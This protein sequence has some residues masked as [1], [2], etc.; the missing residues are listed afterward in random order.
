MKTAKETLPQRTPRP[1]ET[2]GK[3]LRKAPPPT[4]EAAEGPV[5]ASWGLLQP[6]VDKLYGP[7]FNLSGGGGEAVSQGRPQN[8]PTQPVVEQRS[9]V[10][11]A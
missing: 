7:H 9:V 6:A 1:Q 5:S 3:T 10:T 11:A 2:E 8:R 4:Q